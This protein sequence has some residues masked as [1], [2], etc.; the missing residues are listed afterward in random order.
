MAISVPPAKNYASPLIAVPT[1]WGATPPEGNMMIACEIDW[2][3]MGGTNNCVNLN[4][5]N[6]ATL[7]FSQIVAISC[8]N[9]NCGSDV[10][11]IFP[12]TTETM[13]VPAYTPKLIIPVFTNM[14]QF[15]VY[16]PFAQ[17]EDITRF[18]I[19][20]AVPPPI[21][22]PVTSE[23][24]AA[25]FS[26]I[27]MLA[28]GSTTQ[29]VP[30]TISGTLEAAS[31]F[32]FV[33]ALTGNTTTATWNIQDGNGNVLIGGQNSGGAGNVVGQL[34]FNNDNMRVR[35]QNGLKFVQSAASQFGGGQ[36][37]INAYYRTP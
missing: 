31:I 12:D 19:L 2:A 30:V 10:Q 22:V 13:T 5:Q 17:A 14:T 23:Q 25:A 34:V 18:S 32:M 35:F 7:N 37:A 26:N 1:R 36:A 27:S 20:N 28:G 11:F 15:Y 3:T 24:E 21:A 8:D 16:S 33:T 9:S 29:L 6:N 4:L